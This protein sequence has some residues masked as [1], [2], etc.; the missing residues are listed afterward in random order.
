MTS[1][2]FAVTSCSQRMQS[3]ALNETVQQL[4]K[5][6]FPTNQLVRSVDGVDGEPYGMYASW[7]G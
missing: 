4:N 5:A 7:F 3:G 6:A 1:F 2:S